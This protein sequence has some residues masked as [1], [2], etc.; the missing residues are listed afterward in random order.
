LVPRD[1]PAFDEMFI[2]SE[3]L[4]QSM[5]SAYSDAAR[6]QFLLPGDVEEPHESEA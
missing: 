3:L 4:D 6:L 1:S 2:S 5:S